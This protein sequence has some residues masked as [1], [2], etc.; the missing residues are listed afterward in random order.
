MTGSGDA[1]L[2]PPAV[3]VYTP[4]CAGVH[5]HRGHAGQPGTQTG[6]ISADVENRALQAL[7]F[8]SFLILV[9]GSQVSCGNWK[10]DKLDPLREGLHALAAQMPQPLTLVLVSL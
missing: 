5:V 2:L 4:M 7:P 10:A 6:F 8:C 9:G 1:G 3:G